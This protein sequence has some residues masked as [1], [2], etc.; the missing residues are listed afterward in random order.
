LLL[1]LISDDSVIS[2]KASNRPIVGI[3]TEK[4]KSAV[5]DEFLLSLKFPLPSAFDVFVVSD[6]GKMLKQ[7]KPP[8]APFAVGAGTCRFR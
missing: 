2:G 7:L 4:F 3:A 6:P 1:D 5:T 8:R